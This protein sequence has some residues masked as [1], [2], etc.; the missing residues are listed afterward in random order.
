MAQHVFL[1]RHAEAIPRGVLELD[2]HRWLTQRGR[3]RFR[4]VARRLRRREEPDP[5]AAI[6][7]S[8]LPRA[9]MTAELLAR[10]LRFRGPVEVRKEL[11]PDGSVR[12]VLALLREEPRDVALVGHEPLLGLLLYELCGPLPS[13]RLRKGAI[14]A[15][16]LGQKGPHPAVLRYLLEP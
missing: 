4:R 2:D 5:V 8:P 10:A 3:R 1:V 11:G 13:V 9:V 12:P 6:L 14:A 7:T 16:R 15:L